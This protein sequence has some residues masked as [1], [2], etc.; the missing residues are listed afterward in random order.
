MNKDVPVVVVPRS[1][2][3]GWGRGEITLPRQGGQPG[4]R[5]V[6][7]WRGGLVGLCEQFRV[8]W[9]AGSGS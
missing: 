5:A 4:Q 1:V 7:W 8:E 6:A 3:S 9:W 2:I